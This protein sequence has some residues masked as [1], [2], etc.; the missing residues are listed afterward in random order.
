MRWF[1][2]AIYNCNNLGF[3]NPKASRCAWNFSEDGT[4]PGSD[5]NGALT[6]AEFSFVN[7]AGGDFRLNANSYARL[8]GISTYATLMSNRLRLRSLIEVP[9]LYGGPYDP[10]PAAPRWLTAGSQIRTIT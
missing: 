5:S 3:V 1:N 10:Y 9:R 6:L 8:S 4:A 2:T 7:Y